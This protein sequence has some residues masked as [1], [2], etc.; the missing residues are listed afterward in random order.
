[1]NQELERINKL[2]DTAFEHLSPM[3]YDFVITELQERLRK[4]DEV[5][6]ASK[7]LW[8]LKT[9]KSVQGK[10]EYYLKHKPLAWDDLN[11]ALQDYKESE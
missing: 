7:R 5:V 3:D 11:K 8:S 9:T 10:T 1:M 2:I 6:E 4:A